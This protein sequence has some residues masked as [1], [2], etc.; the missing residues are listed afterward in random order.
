MLQRGQYVF[1]SQR[2]KK[3]KDYYTYVKLYLL[4][5]RFNRICGGKKGQYKVLNSFFVFIIHLYTEIE[6]VCSS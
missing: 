1:I 4:E 3:F 6:T 5:Q 2:L